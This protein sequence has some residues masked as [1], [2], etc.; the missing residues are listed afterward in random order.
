VVEVAD[1]RSRK[2]F[3]EDIQALRFHKESGER[4]CNVTFV[5]RLAA[6]SFKTVTYERGVEGFTLSCGTG[7]LAAAVVGVGP[8]AADALLAP[9]RLETPGGI[10]CVQFKG[11]EK[12]AILQ[13]PADL[14]YEGE[15]LMRGDW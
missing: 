13:G 12:S 15:L 14:V 9:V 2:D 4:G 10:L 1:L 8:I 6:N 5:E 11:A 7:V 3:A